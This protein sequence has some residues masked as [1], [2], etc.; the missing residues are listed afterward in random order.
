[1]NPLLL[2][3]FLL[4]TPLCGREN[5]FFPTS[6]ARNIT[7]NVPDSK[8]PLGSL[9][10]RLPDQARLLK[11]VT[12]T[13]QNLDGSI[14]SRTVEVDKAVDWHKSLIITQSSTGTTSVIDTPKSNSSANFGFIRFDTKGKWMTIKTAVP[15][16]R[17]F[18]LSEPN[19]IVIDFK[20]NK[21]FEKREMKLN[22]PPFLSVS[23]A[24]HGKFG[25]A[26][27]TLDGRYHYTLKQTGETIV[28]TC[29]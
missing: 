15:V 6:D 18:V 10:Y 17:H 27:I 7:S 4:L 13:Y 20:N 22:A 28:I 21:I 14:E 19:R 8:P 26:A 1:M 16:M 2:V 9:S 25:R 24:N 12:L 11:E 23:V 29:R 3:P 5:P